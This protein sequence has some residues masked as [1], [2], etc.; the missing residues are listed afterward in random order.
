MDGLSA[1]NCTIK[2]L[3][4]ADWPHVCR[5]YLEGIATGHA[6]FQTG[7]PTWDA[8]D[9]GH[10]ATPRLTARRNEEILGWAALSPYSTRPVYAGVAEV[11]I[12]IA[13]AAR[14]QGIGRTLLS[15]LIQASE[16]AGIWTL[17]AG[18]FPENAG[19]LALHE[20]CGFRTVGRRQRIGRLQGIWRDVILM[21]RRSQSVGIE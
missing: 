14:G 18:I 8:W 15:A 4:P 17:Q 19:S 7:A 2:P 20:H 13:A 21:E 6:T 5:I 9:S 11:S 10:L 12:Y 1:V 16:A 3:L